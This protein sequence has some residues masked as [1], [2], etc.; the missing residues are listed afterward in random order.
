MAVVLAVNTHKHRQPDL[1]GRE[2]VRVV[3][4]IQTMWLALVLLVKDLLEA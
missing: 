1:V 2:V 3:A 4:Q